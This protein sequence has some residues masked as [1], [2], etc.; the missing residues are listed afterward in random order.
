MKGGFEKNLILLT[1]FEEK[2]SV[3]ELHSTNPSEPIRIVFKP[4][5]AG[6]IEKHGVRMRVYTTKD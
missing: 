4:E 5:N 6:V 2:G 3:P 1:P